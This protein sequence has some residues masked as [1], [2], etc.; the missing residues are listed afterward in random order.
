[1]QRRYWRIADPRPL[2]LRWSWL[3]AGTMVILVGWGASSWVITPLP[4]VDTVYYQ[5]LMYHLALVHEMTRSL[6]FQVP[7][8]AGDTLRYHY[9]S[10]ADMA[11]ASMVTGVAPTTVLLRL[12]AVPIGAIAVL[13]L[14]VLG[15]DLTGRWWAGPLAGAGA[16][17]TLPLALGSPNS[18]FAGGSLSYASPS[19]TYAMPLLGLLDWLRSWSF[20]WRWPAP[21]PRRVRCRRSW[22]AWSSPDLS[23]G[24][25]TGGCPG[26][27]LECWARPWSRWRSA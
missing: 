6:P 8:I 2:P 23:S 27:W 7:Q 10:D 21:A 25:A 17:A 14:A 22:P 20:R 18:A 11:T 16:F 3:I 5:D 13:V 12:W 4:P 9:L 15:R 1:M 24:C 19:Q 26:R